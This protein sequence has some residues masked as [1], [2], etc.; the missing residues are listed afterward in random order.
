MVVRA[1]EPQEPVSPGRV[2]QRWR[3]DAPLAEARLS[4]RVPGSVASN[5]SPARWKN[6]FSPGRENW[7]LAAL[8]SE[9]SNHPRPVFTAGVGR[10]GMAQTRHPRAVRSCQERQLLPG[11][12]CSPQAQGTA[13][14][15]GDCPA[16]VLWQLRHV[17]VVRRAI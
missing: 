1:L 7:G 15:H 14:A 16:L 5:S 9:H 6:E 4:S 11:C 10:R 2:P 12:P 17:P 13:T 3:G 8:R